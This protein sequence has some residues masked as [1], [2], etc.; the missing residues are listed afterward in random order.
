M[1]PNDHY[2]VFI[3]LRNGQRGAWLGDMKVKMKEDP[4]PTALLRFGQHHKGGL[5]FEKR[6]PTYVS[7]E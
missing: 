6:L 3:K 1:D 7:S 5:E 4:E 2:D